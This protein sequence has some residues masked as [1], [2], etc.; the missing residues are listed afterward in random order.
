MTFLGFATIFAALTWT[1]TNIT[2]TETGCYRITLPLSQFWNDGGIVIDAAGYASYWDSVSNCYVANGLCR[3]HLK[4]HRRY[5]T[6][7][8][9]ALIC[10]IAFIPDYE[11]LFEHMYWI[12][13]E[14]SQNA[15]VVGNGPTTFCAKQTGSLMCYANDAYTMYWNNGGNIDLLVETIS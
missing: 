6:A 7:N 14:A 10:G 3:P 4:K 1:I 15:F 13:E 5:P 11:Y 8:W 12:T 2:V 9:M